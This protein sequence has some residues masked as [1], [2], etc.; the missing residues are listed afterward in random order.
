MLRKHIVK[1]PQATR[2]P[3]QGKWPLRPLPPCR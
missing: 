3:N 2:F 1:V